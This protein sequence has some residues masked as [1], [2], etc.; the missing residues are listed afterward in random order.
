MEKQSIILRT[1]CPDCPGLVSQLTSWISNYGGNIKHAD[2]HTDQDAGLFLSRIEWNISSPKLDKEEIYHSA[3]IE[4][5]LFMSGKKNNIP[6]SIIMDLAYIFGWDID[7]IYDIRSGDSFELIYEQLYWKGNKVR[8]GD[9]IS[10]NFYRGENK[11]SAV[12][13]FQDGKKDYF[14]QGGNNLKKAFLRSPVEFSY[15]SS[16]YNLNRKH[17]IL[18]TIRAH[19]GVDYAAKTGTPVRT[20][21]EGT[22]IYRANKGGY[23]RLIEIRHFN[24]YTTRYAH[25]S[26]YAK[27][28]QVGSKVDQGDI[29]GYVGKSGLATGPHLHYELRVN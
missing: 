23:G 27:G 28:L 4:D 29:I 1:V 21:G 2:H 18:N 13:F 20:T 12:R 8:N 16:K 17:P 19:T 11:F 3:T 9:I 25:L 7:F 14:S 22:V 26:G 6:E 15:V 5:S 24:E 10:A